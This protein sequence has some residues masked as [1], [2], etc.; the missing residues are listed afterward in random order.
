MSDCKV[1]SDDFFSCMSSSL[2][3]AGSTAFENS[4]W[5][6]EQWLN[7]GIP[8]FARDGLLV[9]LILPFMLFYLFTNKDALASSSDA[10]STAIGKI[11]W[12]GLKRLEMM[13]I[14]FGYLT[15]FYMTALWNMITGTEGKDRLITDVSSLYSM[16]YDS[17]I[18][19][20]GFLCIA[21][22][23][24]FPFNAA[25]FFILFPIYNVRSQFNTLTD[26]N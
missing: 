3:D 15:N 22:I 13:W 23:Q 26:L 18:K 17:L 25:L 21:W 16:D 1:A 14:G 10:P 6:Q 7:E 2:G 9:G 8:A 11:Y 19:L 5:A 24:I 20:L 4:V 12:Y